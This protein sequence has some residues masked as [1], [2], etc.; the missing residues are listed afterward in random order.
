MDEE[1]VMPR[2]STDSDSFK[3]DES[4]TTMPSETS[5]RK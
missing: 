3:E 1:T 5:F 4:S 2:A